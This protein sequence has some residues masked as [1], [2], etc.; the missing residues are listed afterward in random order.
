[1]NSN[2]N[3][4]M[5]RRELHHLLAGVAA[6]LV[7]SVFLALLLHPLFPT[8]TPERIFTRLA[9]L[10]ALGAALHY[11]FTFPE[12]WNR[13]GLAPSSA[14]TGDIL[15]GFRLGLVPFLFFLGLRILF[16]A[17]FFGFNRTLGDLAFRLLENLLAA[18][19]IAFSEE[20]FM[21]GYLTGILV[22][23]GG[24]TAGIL[25]GSLFFSAIHFLRIRPG[26]QIPPEAFGLFCTGIALALPLVA[27]GRLGRSVGLHSAWIFLMKSSPLFF[28]ARQDVSPLLWPPER[29]Y[30]S[31]LA[32]PLLLLTGCL[33]AKVSS[34]G[35][36]SDQ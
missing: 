16:G 23:S 29:L 22:R 25:L 27:T 34:S 7:G 3:T 2:A 36:D 28:I 33:A 4:R 13:V 18:L 10:S 31:P 24:S 17:A 9:A 15:R 21:R 30:A 35:S 11:T 20:F 8:F 12:G 26:Q 1:M 5:R 14:L 6:A 32:W 19:I